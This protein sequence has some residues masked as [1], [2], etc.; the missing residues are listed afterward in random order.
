MSKKITNNQRYV[1]NQRAKGLRAVTVWVPE[2]AVDDLKDLAANCCE[3]Y[4]EKG[5]FHKDLIP[6]M[7]RDIHTGVMGNKSLSEVKKLAEKVK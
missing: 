3:F 7:Y 1:A 4:L 6:S 2:L 5:E